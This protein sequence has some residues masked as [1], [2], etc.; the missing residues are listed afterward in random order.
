MESVDIYLNLE[1]AV[2]RNY[3]E[4]KAKKSKNRVEKELET[5]EDELDEEEEEDEECGTTS[6]CSSSDGEICYII[7]NSVFNATCIM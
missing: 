1:E 3:E 5:D 7:S 2:E 4:G 6:S